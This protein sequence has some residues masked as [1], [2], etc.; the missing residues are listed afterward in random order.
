MSNYKFKL[1]I[2]PK[3]IYDRLIPDQKDRF[4]SIEITSAK[5]LDYGIVEIECL[6]LKDEIIETP[7]R[8]ILHFNNDYITAI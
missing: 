3:D 4:N 8:Q 5:L 1:A 6:A 2:R 7:E